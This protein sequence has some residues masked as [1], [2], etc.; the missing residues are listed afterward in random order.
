MPKQKKVKRE[1]KNLLKVIKIMTPMCWRL[2]PGLWITVL[3]TDCIVSILSVAT[4]WLQKRFFDSVVGVIEG[5]V[6][7]KAAV[8]C[9]IGLGIGKLLE[10]IIRSLSNFMPDVFS[11]YMNGK[12]TYEL[13]E[14]VAK[15]HPIYFEDTK[16]LDYINKATVGAQNA[17]SFMCNFGF[18]LTYYGFYIIAMTFYLF[19]LDKILAFAMLFLFI[20]NALSQA[21][22]MRVFEEAEDMSAPLRR[23]YDYYEE[24]MVSREYYKETR[25]LGA[26]GYFKRLYLEALEKLQVIKYKAQFK[27]GWLDFYMSLFSI[28][29]YAGVLALL[30]RSLFVGNITVG[31]FAAVYASLSQIFYTIQSMMRYS[32]G[33]MSSDYGTINN[34]LNF[35]ELPE[36]DGDEYEC[37]GVVSIDLE[38]ISFAYPCEA[39]EVEAVADRVYKHDHYGHLLD[40]DLLKDVE[41]EK[42]ETKDVVK[43]ATLHINAGETIAI[44]GENGSGKSTII[45]LITGLYKPREGTVKY[46]DKDI[47]KFKYSDLFSKTSA[48]F[49]KYQRYQ[50]TLGE[51]IKIS[52]V[53]DDARKE[54][55]DD[56]CDMAGVAVN[57]D[58][59]PDGYDTVLS[60]EFEGVDLSGGQWQRVAIARAFY[61]SH[62][63]IVLDEPTS[64]IDPYEETRIYNQFAEISKDKTSII[65]THRLGSVK[66]ADR[67]VVMK[68]G[69][70][71]EVG[72]HDELLENCKEY[73]RLYKAQ[74]QWYE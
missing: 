56:I 55:V 35:L 72:T 43:N 50:M 24:C 28:A 1:R 25:L 70:I 66:L 27:T 53:D 22:R 21:L 37:D 54:E 11:G 23:Q 71:V 15:L 26:F 12:L 44:V 14:K 52:S 57:S 74:E 13:H 29:G 47:S 9:L 8:L 48:V 41:E 45:R 10:E 63:I 31:A 17:V 5:D 58:N 34:Y 67:I 20:P 2:A 69:E 51:N 33:S 68:D 32:I 6:I 38:N 62:G 7:I 61:R 60:R 73:A 40:T 59:Y 46:N 39:G 30:I 19:T 36:D 18:I 3:L 4:V 65:V 16:T 49:Q 42:H 64:A